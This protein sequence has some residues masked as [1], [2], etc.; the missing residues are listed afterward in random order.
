MGSPRGA[1]DRCGKTGRKKEGSRSLLHAG[2]CL[3]S[4]CL[5]SNHRLGHYLLCTYVG[6]AHSIAGYGSTY[7]M[8]MQC[9]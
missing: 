3:R 7:A 2:G 4:A 5:L 6:Y 9:M 8:L 1:R